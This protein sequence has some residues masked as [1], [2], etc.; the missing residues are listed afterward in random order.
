MALNKNQ[1][2]KKKEEKKEEPNLL[3]SQVEFLKSQVTHLQEQLTQKSDESS[4]QR[5]EA[6]A[7]KLKL[8]NEAL[9]EEADLRKTLGTAFPVGPKA[10]DED[11]EP[12][13]LDPQ[14]MVS[15]MGEAVGKAIDASTKLL[16]G[17]FDKILASRDEKIKNTETAV[18]RLIAG[19]S[20]KEAQESNPDFDTYREDVASI[21]SKTDGLSPQDAYLLAKS[22]RA[23]TQPDAKKIE[24]ERPHSSVSRT[25]DFSTPPSREPAEDTRPRNTRRD[26]RDAC[27]KAIDE[28]L[29]KRSG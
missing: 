2:E 7:E 4:Q 18:I 27:G 3:T 9:E 20:V 1:E 5:L 10:V 22:R 17:K 14:Q 21:L 11:G 24:S 28:M 6:A 12:T 26:F 23:S 29:A 8:Q 16:E 13:S 25:E 15:I 19:M